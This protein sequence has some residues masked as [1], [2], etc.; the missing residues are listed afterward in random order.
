M[1][2]DVARARRETPG[3]QRVLHFDNAGASLMPQPVLDRV[4]EHLRLEAEIGGYQAE[5]E[6]ADELA[7]VY[8]LVAALIGCHPAEVAIVENA[9]RA[10]D[11]AFYSIA[12]EPGDRILTSRAEYASN[13][14]AYLQVAERTGAVVEAVPNDDAGQ[15]SV[16]ALEEMMD[17]RV[18]LVSITH[19]P[20]NGGLVNPAAAVGRIARNHGVLYL[21]DACQS[22][23]QMP[24]DVTEIGCDMLAGT[25]RKYLRGP[26]GVGFLHVRRP[27]ITELEPP[28]LDLQAAEWTAADGY[29][30]RDDA[31]RFEN[32]EGNVAGRLGMGT[33]IE[34]ALSMGLDTIA[35]FVRTLADLLRE[36]LTDLPGVRVTDLG[37]E[38]CGIVTFVTERLS[39]TAVKEVLADQAINVSVS[40]RSSTLL[41]MDE[42][43]LDEVVR[44]S[45]HYFNTEQEVHR[46]CSAVAGLLRAG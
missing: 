32:W 20:T 42:R 44:A 4:V 43:D 3:C 8:G 27:L 37:A 13:Y 1:M 29:R 39:A 24:V 38:K 25:S 31:R 26:R 6:V 36:L 46:F 17:H 5:A 16:A 9:T 22:V 10:W 11:M 14:I 41:D 7:G 28:L 34:Y 19:V 21:L 23:G 33:A 15:I 12:F 35:H 18:R 40:T 45:V 30:I 2:I